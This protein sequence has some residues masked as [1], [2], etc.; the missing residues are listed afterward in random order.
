[1]MCNRLSLEHLH[2]FTKKINKQFLVF[3]KN[4]L[5]PFPLYGKLRK[6][7]NLVNRQHICGKPVDF[8]QF[9]PT[10]LNNSISY[11]ILIIYV[12]IFLILNLQEFILKWHK[13]NIIIKINPTH[14]IKN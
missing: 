8:I 1:M 11:K 14:L 6:I 7:S 5:A 13:Y 12:V 10:I 9:L 4:K 3:F 2:K